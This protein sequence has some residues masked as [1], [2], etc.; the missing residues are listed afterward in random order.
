MRRF[1][2]V[3]RDISYSFSPGYFG[4]K[5]KELGLE[6][7][8]YE[9]FDLPEI[10]GFPDLLA[11]VPDLQGLNV[12]I[13][14]KEAILP[15]LDTLDP[16]AREIGAVNTIR[17]RG[18]R[19]EGFNTDVT[20]FRESLRPLLAA[21]DKNALILGTGGASKAVAHGLGQLGIASRFVSRTPTGG[22]LAYTDLDPGLLR[23]HQ[24]LINC[25]PLGTFPRV[26]QAPPLPYEALNAG[27]LLYDL[28]YNPART[29]FLKN[30]MQQGAR[31]KNG[32]E[33]LQR[34]AEASWEIWNS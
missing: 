26:D 7:C 3:G 6:D 1:G 19:K 11:R 28:I 23:R 15:Y 30:G 25:T 27:H 5:F 29:T 22:Q 33:M 17:L 2:L 9:I 31:I 14:Y 10:E 4:A 12:T 16:E 18:G 13:P 34:Q 21:A 24:I 32:L 20:G 8:T